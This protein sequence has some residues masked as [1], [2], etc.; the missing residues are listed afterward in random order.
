MLTLFGSAAVSLMVIAY[1]LEQYNPALTLRF[2]AGCV[3]SSIYGFLLGSLPF[4]IL[5]LLWA[6]VALRRFA[7]R[8]LLGG[9]A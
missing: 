2:A 3:C 7:L 8:R 5:E 9:D 1:A 6:V 4:G